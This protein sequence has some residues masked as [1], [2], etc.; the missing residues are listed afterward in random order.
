MYVAVQA[1]LI[2][3]VTPGTIYVLVSMR[4]TKCALIGRI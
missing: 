2:T 4:R 3:M 1:D